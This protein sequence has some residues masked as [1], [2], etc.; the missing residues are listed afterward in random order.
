MV[1]VTAPPKKEEEKLPQAPPL[2]EGGVKFNPD[3]TVDYTVGGKTFKLSPEE[4]NNILKSTGG[5]QNLPAAASAKTAEILGYERLP[6]Q[7]R[8]LRQ[9]LAK[10]V[11]SGQIIQA[12]I[13]PTL[14]EMEKNIPV[15]MKPGMKQII[16]GVETTGSLKKDIGIAAPVI[17][18][19]A[20]EIYD[21]FEKSLFGARKSGRVQKAETEFTDAT[22]IIKQNIEMVKAGNKDYTDALRDFENALGAI[23]RLERTTKGLGKINLRYWLDN[24]KELETSILNEKTILENLRAEL[25]TAAQTAQINEAKLRAGIK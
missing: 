25:I 1:K 20:A 8:L 24:G 22:N 9:E 19:T 23:S 7:E 13:I 21:T 10:G 4:Y 17:A 12:P 15:K 2:I 3:K 5:N 14:E 16:P 6:Q 11:P 18:Q